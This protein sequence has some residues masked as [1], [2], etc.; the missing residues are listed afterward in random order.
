MSWSTSVELRD[1][2]MRQ[3][4]RAQL[5]SVYHDNDQPRVLT[6]R[7]RDCVVQYIGVVRSGAPCSKPLPSLRPSRA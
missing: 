1:R 7:Q 6:Y 4:V 5:A 2:Q 3:H